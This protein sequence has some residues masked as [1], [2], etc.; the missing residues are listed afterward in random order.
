M[1]TLSIKC[2]TESS[3]SSKISHRRLIEGDGHLQNGISQ[4]CLIE[5]GG[6]L[7]EILRFNA[8]F[9]TSRYHF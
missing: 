1:T 7:Q 3:D 6:Q 5:R 2:L 4:I 9:E 8:V